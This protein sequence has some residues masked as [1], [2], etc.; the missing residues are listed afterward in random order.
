MVNACFLMME[1]ISST[2]RNHFFGGDVD[3]LCASSSFFRMANPIFRI[4]G[5]NAPPPPNTPLAT[6]LLTREMRIQIEKQPKNSSRHDV[7]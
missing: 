3:W 7:S 4:C 6:A 2:K 1:K 5:Y